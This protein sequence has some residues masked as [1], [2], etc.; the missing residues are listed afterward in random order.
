MNS[1]KPNFSKVTV[2]TGLAVAS[3]LASVFAPITSLNAAQN[4]SLRLDTIAKNVTTGTA[5]GDTTNATLGQTVRVRL[6]LENLTSADLND[7]SVK[8]QLPSTA[9]SSINVIGTAQSSAVGFLSDPTSVNLTSGIGFVNYVPNTTMLE[10]IGGPVTNQPDVNG[11]GPLFTNQGLR[12]TLNPGS[13]AQM[14]VY[15]DVTVSNTAP[16]MAPVKIDFSKTVRNVTQGTGF[17][18]TTAAKNGDILEFNIFVHNGCT[19]GTC[20]DFPV[21]GVVLKDAL[22]VSNG[23]ASN[24]ATFSSNEAGPFSGTASI[25]IPSGATVTY[26]AGSTKITQSTTSAFNNPDFGT[27]VAIADVSGTSPLLTS[28]GWT[29]D[30]GQGSGVLPFCNQYRRN[31]LFQVKVNVPTTPAPQG[32]VLGASLPNTGPESLPQLVLAAMIPL[33]AL[34][35]R[36]RI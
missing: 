10:T 22:S 29:F 2:L 14:F 20:S 36:F 30:E 27:A 25:S 16:A 11:N 23:T 9:S 28:A 6:N 35:R 17:G 4:S 24:T 3:L 8:A 1:F 19:D 12:L 33:G 21:T 32:Q 13:S 26:I 15:F 34:I 31:V 5:Y 18:S 7:I